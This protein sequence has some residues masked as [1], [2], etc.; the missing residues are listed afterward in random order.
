MKEEGKES[1][2]NAWCNPCPLSLVKQIFLTIKQ[3]NITLLISTTRE[4]DT[5]EFRTWMILKVTLTKNPNYHNG[6]NASIL[7]VWRLQIKNIV[8]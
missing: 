4:N 3:S 7:R 2:E 1:K 6:M 5:K 8:I